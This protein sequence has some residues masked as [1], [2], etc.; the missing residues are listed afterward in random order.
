MMEAL[1]RA[2]RARGWRVAVHNDYRQDGK[3]YTFWLFTQG[4]H[5]VKGEG[6]TDYDALKIV[7]SHPLVSGTSE[8]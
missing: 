7:A 4:D 5:A 1:L 8:K 2:I 6:P 3:D